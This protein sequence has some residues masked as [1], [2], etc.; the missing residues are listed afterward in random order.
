AAA[1]SGPLIPRE[2]AAVLPELTGFRVSRVLVEEGAYVKAGETL[3]ELDPALLTAQVEQQAALAAQARVQAEQARAEA[4]RVH[5]LDG[6]GVLSQEQLEQ[7]RF[8]ARSSQATAEAQAAALKDLRTRQSKLAVTA[9][10]SGLVL[11]RTVRPGD[12]AAAG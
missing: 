8:A 9:P 12:L 1:A 10:V 11:E 6:Q 4:A 7:R 2:E 3:V 5:G